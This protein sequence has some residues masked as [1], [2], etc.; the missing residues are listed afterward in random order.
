MRI[1]TKDDVRL[2][3]GPSFR[4]TAFLLRPLVGEQA[5]HYRF[6]GSY[7]FGSCKCHQFW[8]IKE[9]G[10]HVNTPL[11]YHLSLWILELIGEVLVNVLYDEL[12]RLRLHPGRHEACKIEGGVAVQV[13]LVVY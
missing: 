2:I 1:S 4:L 5:K 12:C 6:R 9:A 7:R 3:K 13:H 11:V 8:G 10:K